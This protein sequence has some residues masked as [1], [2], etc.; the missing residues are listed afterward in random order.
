MYSGPVFLW[1]GGRLLLIRAAISA[2]TIAAVRTPVQDTLSDHGSIESSEDPEN[3][4]DCGADGQGQILT[5][6]R[7]CPVP[8]GHEVGGSQQN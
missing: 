6:A 2:A 1:S 4:D 8:P 5:V 3:G 7:A